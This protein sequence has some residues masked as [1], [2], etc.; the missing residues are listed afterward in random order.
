MPVHHVTWDRRDYCVV[1]N[2]LILVTIIQCSKS[3]F[4]PVFNVKAA[5][6]TRDA[7]CRSALNRRHH[8]QIGARRWGFLQTLQLVTMG[9]CESGS[10]TYW[11]TTDSRRIVIC[12]PSTGLIGILENPL[13]NHGATVVA[14]EPGEVDVAGSSRGPRLVFS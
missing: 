11:L 6:S 4:R 1:V 7:V 14:I 3:S 2:V 9:R 5:W 8:L 10:S 13:K 12:D